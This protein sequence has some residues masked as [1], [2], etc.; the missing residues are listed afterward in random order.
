MAPTWE[1]ILSNAK[2]DTDAEFAAKVSSLTKLTD[3]EIMNLVP[4]GQNRETLAVVMKI[5]T[6]A[7]KDNAAKAEAIRNIQG[8]VNILVPIL[9]TL[10]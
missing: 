2:N 4:N 3:A 9:L 6:D 5:V 10:A 7:T 1:E 8:V